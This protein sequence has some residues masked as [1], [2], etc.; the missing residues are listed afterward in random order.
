M[1]A[2]SSQP[3]PLKLVKVGDTRLRSS[4]QPEDGSSTQPAD[5]KRRRG[6]L[7][8]SQPS[9]VM[10]LGRYG[11]RCFGVVVLVSV[12]CRAGRNRINCKTKFYVKN[13]GGT[14]SC[15]CRCPIA[16]LA[17]KRTTCHYKVKWH[18]FIDSN[19]MNICRPMRLGDFLA[20]KDLQKLNYVDSVERKSLK[21]PAVSIPNGMICLT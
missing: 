21:N 17:K 3:A 16:L 7:S 8:A 5:M 14:N 15:Q 4:M 13:A 10:L 11:G 2:S 19:F 1:Q 12:S 20:N 18:G 9:L 6:R